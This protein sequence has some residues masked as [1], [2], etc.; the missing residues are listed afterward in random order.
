M[1]QKVRKNY[2]Q[3]SKSASSVLY[4]ND[5]TVEVL[6]KTNSAVKLFKVNDDKK[7]EFLDNVIAPSATNPNNVVNKSQL[8]T[9]ITNEQITRQGLFNTLQSGLLAE[10]QDR[11][12]A[13]EEKLQESKE[14]T[15]QKITTLVNFAPEALNTLQEL[16]QA[17]GSDPNFA[18]NIANTFNL[19]NQQIAL[20]QSQVN[21]V[22]NAIVFQK[23]IIPL[24]QQI[25]DNG[26]IDLTQ[27]A[28]TG[29]TG[30]FVDGIRV[31][32]NVDYTISTVN[33]KT[34]VTLIN[35]PDNTFF[36][37]QENDVIYVQYFLSILQY[38]IQFNKEMYVLTA[39]DIQN[40]YVD[41]TT[42]AVDESLIVFNG[43]VAVHENVDYLISSVASKTRVTL[44]NDIN[45]PFFTEDDILYFQYYS[46]V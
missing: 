2:A 28:A 43:R 38:D 1:A 34:R 10:I 27:K 23:E 35:S 39:S 5:R 17:I 15:D 6:D 13:D 41:L 9:A 30:V 22:T 24:T 31:H 20:L 18:L 4:K 45:E 16:A 33:D 44:L 25:L 40:G 36:S 7:I 42:E 21:S 29:S 3:K 32:E 11:Q 37:A 12:V 19:L 46:K 8:D 14:Y 26:Y